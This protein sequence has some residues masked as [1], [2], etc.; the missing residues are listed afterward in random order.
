[1]RTMENEKGGEGGWER[2]KE[3]ERNQKG[4][5]LSP[6]G[7]GRELVRKNLKPEGHIQNHELSLIVSRPCLPPSDE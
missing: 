6:P 7:P 5:T 1:M 3:K 4:R 2:Q